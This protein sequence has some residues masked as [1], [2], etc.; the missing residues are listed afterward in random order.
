MT[1]ALKFVLSQKG[2]RCEEFQNQTR[3]FLSSKSS[4]RLSFRKRKV[5]I[6]DIPTY[7]KAHPPFLKK[8]VAEKFY[9]NQTRAVLSQNSSLLLS[10]AER[11]VLILDIPTYLKAEPS[12]SH[13]LYTIKVIVCNM[14]RV[15]CERCGSVAKT[16]YLRLSE[17]ERDAF[18][19]NDYRWKSRWLAVG[20]LCEK[21]GCV[22]VQGK[23]YVEE[24]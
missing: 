6:L 18:D 19:K 9:G 15:R 11:K 4:L 8:E 16:L 13:L 3:A 24:G 1:H 22:K 17:R 23:F 10:F 5:L 12:F 21:C 20:Y 2:G 7:L 14:P